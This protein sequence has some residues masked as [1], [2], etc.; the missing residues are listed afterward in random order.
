MRG[1]ERTGSGEERVLMMSQAEERLLMLSQNKQE[2]N[3]AI[4]EVMKKD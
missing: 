3:Y 4:E 1:E 2:I